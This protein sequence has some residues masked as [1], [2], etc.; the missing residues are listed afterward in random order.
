MILIG[1]KTFFGL[2]EGVRGNI[3][4]SE[5]YTNQR[6]REHVMMQLKQ[7]NVAIEI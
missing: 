1:R 5:T 4:V 3:S 2:A 6:A 7:W